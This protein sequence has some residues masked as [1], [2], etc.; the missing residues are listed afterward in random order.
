MAKLEKVS[1]LEII[2]V[3][4]PVG[5]S[6]FLNTNMTDDVIAVQALLRFIAAH[7]DINWPLSDLPLPVGTMDKKTANL[8]LRFQKQ[9]NINARK[10]KANVWVAED[11]RVSPAK[12]GSKFFLGRGIYT[13]YLMNQAAKRVAETMGLGNFIDII[14]ELNSGLRGKLRPGI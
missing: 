2:N 11:G 12:G 10:R 3:S 4:G 7:P 9:S 1:D 14:L 13:I 5:I 8:I 6:K